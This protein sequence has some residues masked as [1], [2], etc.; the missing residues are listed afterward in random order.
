LGSDFDGMKDEEIVNGVENI[1]KID[2][3]MEEMKLQGF[4]NEEIEKV[5]W[6]NW[7]NYFIR[8]LD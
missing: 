8:N 5:M 6:R 3:I 4:S 7:A 2:N 1:S